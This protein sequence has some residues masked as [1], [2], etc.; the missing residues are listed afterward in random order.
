MISVLV[1]WEV[2]D[3]FCGILIRH[4]IRALYLILNLVS[5]SFQ[6]VDD[7]QV[8]FQVSVLR[9]NISC[10]LW[11]SLF[12][13]QIIL[14]KKV[15]LTL[16]QYIVFGLIL[17]RRYFFV[18][19]AGIILEELVF[20]EA[21]LNDRFLW[22]GHPFRLKD[23]LR[24]RLLMISNLL[25]LVFINCIDNQICTH[26]NTGIIL[27]CILTG[28]TLGTWYILL[29]LYVGRVISLGLY[30]LERR[31]LSFAWSTW[32]PTSI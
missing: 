16:W 30:I 12:I 11:L 21:P 5:P 7:M 29:V 31:F 28:I 9:T 8:V 32:V 23:M 17:V 10:I 2:A 4:H 1:V 26:H 3:W 22:V 15:F 13:L 25:V 24:I 20:K 14:G 18:E 27:C 6:T 19:R